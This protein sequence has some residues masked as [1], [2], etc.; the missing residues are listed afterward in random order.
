[1]NF[2]VS[3]QYPF[4]GYLGL[5]GYVPVETHFRRL[6]LINLSYAEKEFQSIYSVS[7][8]SG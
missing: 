4:L 6:F 5:G 2:L 3:F 7:K 1:M 8:R